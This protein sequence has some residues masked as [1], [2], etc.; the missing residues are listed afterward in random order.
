MHL[1]GTWILSDKSYPR[2]IMHFLLITMINASL[3]YHPSVLEMKYCCK[4]E[5]WIMRVH[6]TLYNI[7]RIYTVVRNACREWHK[8]LPDLDIVCIF[9][10][11]HPD[12][13]GCSYTH[14]CCMLNVHCSQNYQHN[15]QDWEKQS[16]IFI[17]YVLSLEISSLRCIRIKSIHFYFT[18]LSSQI[19]SYHSSQGKQ[20]N[21]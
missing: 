18:I 9:L 5:R 20:I 17:Y 4:R 2:I 14:C 11:H 8:L 13:L 1:T 3:K 19:I 10:I 16:N 21:E 12:T 6:I 15:L 7:N